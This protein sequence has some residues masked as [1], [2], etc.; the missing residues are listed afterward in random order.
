MAVVK[1]AIHNRLSDTE[2]ET[3]QAP[4]TTDEL[5]SLQESKMVVIK[6]ILF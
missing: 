1:H 3:E 6:N 5:Q 4:L 2:S